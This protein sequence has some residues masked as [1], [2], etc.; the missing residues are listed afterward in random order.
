MTAQGRLPGAAGAT[1]LGRVCDLDPASARAIRVLRGHAAGCALQDGD[2]GR[3]VDFCAVILAHARRAL[4][5]RAPASPW[6]C[7]DEMLFAQVFE[8]APEEPEDTALL[9]CLILRADLAQG[10]AHEARALA[11]MLRRGAASGALR[12]PAG[13]RL[14]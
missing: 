13:E 8:T 4:V 2:A 12:A 3:L 1:I 10:L 6:V 9:L 5:V 11:L 14:H 7:A